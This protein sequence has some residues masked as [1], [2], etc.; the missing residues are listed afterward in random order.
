MHIPN[1]K[2]LREI[3][4]EVPADYYFQLNYFQNLWHEWKWIVI[5]HLV[6]KNGKTPKTI[7]EVG[8]NA[9]H[10]SGLLHTIFPKAKITG[11]DVYDQS[12][13]E[14]KK[15]YPAITFK[16]ADAHKL[17][18]RDKSFDLVVCSETIEH[19]VDPAKVFHEISRVLKPGG[20]VLVEMDSGS[21]LFRT[22]WWFWTTFGKGKV[23]KNAHLHPFTA[24]ELELLIRG[25]GF[26]IDQKMFSHLGMA[27][28]FLVNKKSS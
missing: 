7:L 2:R 14:A 3:W 20:E 6:S 18:F 28:S 5:K 26:T 25:N 10:L 1:S 16:V 4:A 13:V 21:A 15:R 8:C 27:V 24:K 11:I 17:P 12:I 19:V 23:W 22:I 9:G